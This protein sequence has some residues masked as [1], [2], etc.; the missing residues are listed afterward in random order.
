[1]KKKIIVIMIVLIILIAAFFIIKKIVWNYQVAH[2]EKIV[3]LSKDEVLTSIKKRK[4][5]R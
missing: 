4:V 3:V 2:A 1:M 5:N